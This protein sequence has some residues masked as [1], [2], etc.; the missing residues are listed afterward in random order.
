MD[1]QEIIRRDKVV[2]VTLGRAAAGLQGKS[3]G[4]IKE[5]AQKEL[6]KEAQT[7]DVQVV[8]ASTVAQGRM[9][10]I[11]ASKEQAE[12]ARANARWV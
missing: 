11:V 3:V 5:M 2:V 6:Q 1:V 9:E 8:G 10:I 12:A 4:T 7:K